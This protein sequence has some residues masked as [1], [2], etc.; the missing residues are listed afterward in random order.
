MDAEA[1]LEGFIGKYSPPVAAQ[2]RAARAWMRRR[3]PGA[4]ELVYDNYNALVVGYGAGETQ[5]DLVFSLAAYPRWV[6]LFFVDGATLEDPTGRLKGSGVRVRHIV[7]DDPATL[8]APDVAGLVAQAL[9]RRPIPPGV[10]GVLIKS[11]S[12]RQRPRRPG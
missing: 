5:A 8:E 12:A 9:A 2:V 11:V 10:G 7:I 4:I 3:L 1:E 6:S